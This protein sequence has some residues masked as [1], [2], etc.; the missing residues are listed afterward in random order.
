MEEV[1]DDPVL[2]ENA[3]LKVATDSKI[4]V[5][6]QKMNVFFTLMFGE[7]GNERIVIS[8][9]FLSSCLRYKELSREDEEYF[10]RIFKYIR[11]YY[12]ESP[13]SFPS[14]ERSFFLRTLN[15]RWRLGAPL[16]FDEFV[17]SVVSR[18]KSTDPLPIGS[19]I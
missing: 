19:L 6:Q 12:D 3:T 2:G 9:S 17:K 8:K 1:R 10:M 13:E 5:Y 7:S 16:N 14:E 15:L 4:E 11:T 18:D